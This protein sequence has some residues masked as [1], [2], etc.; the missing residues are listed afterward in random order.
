MCFCI[1]YSICVKNVLSTLVYVCVDMI[2]GWSFICTIYFSECVSSAVNFPQV[3]LSSVW[4]KIDL[5]FVRTASP[6]T[7]Y[8]CQK[9]WA[10]V[11]HFLKDVTEWL[12]H[13]SYSQ[14]THTHVCVCV[15]I[16]VSLCASYVL[17]W[18]TVGI[19]LYSPISKCFLQDFVN[20]H[21]HGI[22]INIVKEPSREL[23][24]TRL[25]CC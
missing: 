22:M 3:K 24:Y 19:F 1:M 11:S 5:S 2:Y 25:K 18:N 17:Y 13:P 20:T 8:M 6:M 9:V 10:R 16:S 14:S 12:I 21:I 15:W 4:L 23:Q 7:Y